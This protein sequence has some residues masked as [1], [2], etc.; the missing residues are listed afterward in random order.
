MLGDPRCSLP[1]VFA[2]KLPRSQSRDAGDDAPGAQVTKQKFVEIGIG[3]VLTHAPF[4]NRFHTA[5]RL[6]L[7]LV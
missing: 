3:R 4:A 6:V 7:C 5:P 2:M 1:V